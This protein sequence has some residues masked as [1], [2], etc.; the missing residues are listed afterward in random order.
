MPPKM[1]DLQSEQDLYAQFPAALPSRVSSRKKIIDTVTVRSPRRIPKK[2]L[3]FFQMDPKTGL[4]LAEE[5]RSFLAQ[6][7]MHEMDEG[8]RIL[9]RCGHAEQARL[10]KNPPPKMH[11]SNLLA[12]LR[13]SLDQKTVQNLPPEEIS[14]GFK[15][16]NNQIGRLTVG[17][18]EGRV[19]ALTSQGILYKDRNEDALLLVP[20]RGIMA[21]LDGMGGHAGGNIASGIVTDFM[22]YALKE[23]RSLEKAITYANDAVIERTRNDPRL[24]GMHPM[25]TTLVCCQIRKN[26]LQSVH[27]GDSKLLVIRNSRIIHESKDHTNG[28]DLLRDGLIDQETAHFLNHILSRS[29]GCDSIFASRDLESSEI[30]LEAGDRVLLATDGVTDNFFSRDFSLA[31][32]AQMA[33]EG[34]VTDAV[35]EIHQACL[36][37]IQ[38]ETLPDGRPS[39]ADNLTVMVYEHGNL[40]R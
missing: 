20:E 39:K 29:L 18:P 13:R 25:G 26:R 38:K 28:Q 33:G 23:G 9:E 2:I 19:A 35:T 8:I 10:L 40:K 12:L 4:S 32:L 6:V 36:D 21:V 34:S 14:L 31:E 27:V 24:G 17:L 15:I 16:R 22:E 37:R 3:S 11:L 7:V 5:K 30:G 1:T